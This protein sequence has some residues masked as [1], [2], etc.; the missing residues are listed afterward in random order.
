MY[1]RVLL[2][3]SGEQLAGEFD[4]GIDPKACKWLAAEVKKVV[5]AGTQVVIMVGGGNFAR[6]RQTIDGISTLTAH[7][8]GIMGIVMNA[9]ALK[10]VFESAG[11][12]TRSMSSV[13]GE[14]Y[15]EP[16]SHHG[17][18]AYLA[19]DRVV[20]AVG[21][22]RPYLTSDT[23]SVLMGL[24]LSCQAVM[25]ATKVDGVYDDDPAQNSH[26]K[27]FQEL[28]YQQALEDP[29]IKVMDK[30]A[31]GLAMEHNMPIIVFDSMQAG[32]ILKA[33][34]GETIGTKIS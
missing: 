21:A 11:V 17:A 22:L 23:G 15:L 2:K 26:A 20:I 30:A 16:F 32:N 29:K 18:E 8:L 13:I 5:D 3:L 28:T 25:K 7:K 9:M 34:K 6:G 33:A 24:E 10:D 4:G 27:K 1:K 31:M 14:P 12:P 19:K